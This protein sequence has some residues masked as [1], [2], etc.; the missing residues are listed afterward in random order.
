MVAQMGRQE[1]RFRRGSSLRGLL[2]GCTTCAFVLGSC[3]STSAQAH[4]PSHL[5]GDQ[6]STAQVCSALSHLA[7]LDGPHPVRVVEPVLRLGSHAKNVMLRTSAVRQLADLQNAQTRAFVDGTTGPASS[8]ATIN[9]LATLSTK[10]F[11]QREERL[12]Q[13]CAELH[14]PGWVK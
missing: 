14:A 5:S 13:L 1:R 3:S 6:V 2:I 9:A 8:S 10:D 4:L 7:N 12:P 11:I